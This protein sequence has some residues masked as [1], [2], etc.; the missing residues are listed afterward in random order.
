M[1][2]SSNLLEAIRDGFFFLFRNKTATTIIFLTLALVYFGYV[3][4]FG[5]LLTAQTL[6]KG[7]F[8]S[9]EELGQYQSS[10][11]DWVLGF[12]DIVV[13]SVLMTVTTNLFTVLYLRLRPPVPQ[14]QPLMEAPPLPS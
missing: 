3:V 7:G 9:P 6:A 11:L 4:L 10:S 5:L 1:L 8:P 2:E 12:L 14:S 13:S